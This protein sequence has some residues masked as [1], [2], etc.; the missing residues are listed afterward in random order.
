MSTYLIYGAHA[1]NHFYIKEDAPL[2]AAETFPEL[3]DAI[4]LDHEALRFLLQYRELRTV[5]LRPCN[6]VGP[7][8]E[9][10]LMDFFRSG[11]CPKLMGFDP[12]MQFIHESDMAEVIRLV[13]EGSQSGVYNIAGEGVAPY[14][15]AANL[16]GARTVPLPLLLSYG[17]VSLLNLINQKFPPHLLDYLRYPTIISDDKFRKDYDYQP[18]LDLCQTMGKSH[19]A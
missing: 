16:A 8:S 1:S 12:L 14:S 19:L 17:L 4:E 13:L 6:I 9:S 5:I 15:A 18:R 11:I 2:R 7:H 3:T 10:V